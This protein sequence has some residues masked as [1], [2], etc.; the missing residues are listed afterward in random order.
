MKTSGTL[1][2]LVVIVMT[3]ALLPLG[4]VMASSDNYIGRVIK[5]I[6]DVQKINPGTGEEAQLGLGDRVYVQDQMVTNQAAYVKVLMKDDTIFQLGANSHFKFDKFKFKTKKDRRAKYKLLYGQLRSLFTVKAKSKDHLKVDTPTVSMGIRGTEFATQVYSGKRGQSNT[7]VVL[8]TGKIALNSNKI[9]KAMVMKPGQMF[10]A[11]KIGSR[12]P[13]LVKVAPKMFKKLVLGLNKG[14]AVFINDAADKKDK[15]VF[16]APVAAVNQ[17]Q[18]I[19]AAKKAV[20]TASSSVRLVCAEGFH[21]N[22]GG[23]QCL[24]DK[25]PT[26]IAISKPTATLVCSA[27]YHLNGGGNKCLA[28][29][30]PTSVAVTPTA[31][32]PS[33]SA[34]NGNG[35]SNAGGNGNSNAGG[36]TVAEVEV[37]VDIPVVSNGN[38]NS[39]AG[40]NGNSNAGGNGNSNAGGNGN[41]NAGGNGNNAAEQAAADAAAAEQ[42]AADAAAAPSCDK[43]TNGNKKG[44]CK[45]TPNGCVCR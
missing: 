4:N 22:G 16:K 3:L 6:G 17:G 39:N 43:F 9:K 28:D 12:A 2:R 29:K 41:S 32:G 8:F 7:D 31:T 26:A 20:A 24:A 1:S 33:V 11:T 15:K 44:Q 5:V 13:V 45:S 18:I 25:K 35:N 19:K 21:L 36:N 23:N 14:G 34:T 37:E 30:K 42:A 40:G 38:G 27:G 10:D